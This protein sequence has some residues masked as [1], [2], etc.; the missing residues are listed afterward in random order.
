MFRKLEKLEQSNRELHR[1]GKT[2]MAS[3]FLLQ[4]GNLKSQQTL[5]E[6]TVVWF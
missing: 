1:L 3:F 4:L 5:Q 6:L 2:Y